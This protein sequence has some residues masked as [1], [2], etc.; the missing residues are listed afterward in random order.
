MMTV[1]TDNGKYSEGIDT[2]PY[3]RAFFRDFSV[4]PSCYNCHFKTQKRV[5]DFTIWDCFNINEID[6]SF[7]D[8]RGTTRVLIQSEKGLKLINKLENVKIQELN[9]STAIHK[10]REM[11][12]SIAYNGK[13]KKFFE[14]VNNEEEEVVINK[15]YPVNLK[16][17]CNSAIRK[18][19]CL[20]G[21]YSMVKNLIKKI[22]SFG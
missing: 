5:S 19:L 12:N 6:K 2:D 10:V 7:N 4:R 22:V 15:Y 3:L 18:L 8:D 13:R 20:T 11:T 17:R 21:T 14:D 9:I 1:I 16:T